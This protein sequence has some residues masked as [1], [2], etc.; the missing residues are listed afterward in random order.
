M[1]LSS[2][3]HILDRQYK[4]VYDKPATSIKF[5]L[6]PVPSLNN[7][8]RNVRINCRIITSEGKA[9][10]ERA[11]G[12][13]SRAAHNQH[14]IL[15]KNEKLVMELTFFWPDARKRDCDNSLKLLGDTLEGILYE[16][17]KWLLPRVLDFSIDRESPRVQIHIFK[18]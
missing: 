6:P 2:Y 17:D 9:W 7:V 4:P 8:Y 16:N 12:I 13:A 18:K 3:K 14:W 11:Q 5:C 15:S 1:S 10:Q